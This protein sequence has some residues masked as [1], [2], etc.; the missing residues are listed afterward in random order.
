MNIDL[1]ILAKAVVAGLAKIFKILMTTHTGLRKKR[2]G[3]QAAIEK[4]ISQ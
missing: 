1:L 4:V 2:A 3:D